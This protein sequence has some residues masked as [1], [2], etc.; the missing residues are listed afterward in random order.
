VDS[1][2]PPLH[3]TVERFA[4]GMAGPDAGPLC[5]DPT[6]L[7]LLTCP[8][9]HRRLVAACSEHGALSACALCEDLT[10]SAE[11]WNPE[12]PVL[13]DIERTRRKLDQR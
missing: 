12:H 6:T 13:N 11:P 1:A 2:R 5:D 10:G 7:L 9:G 4:T 3:P 8:A